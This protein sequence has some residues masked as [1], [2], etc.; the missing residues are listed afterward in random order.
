MN[1]P[2]L[3]LLKLDKSVNVR[4]ADESDI[5]FIAKAIIES[6]KSGTDIFAYSKI[7]EIDE[8]SFFE[9]LVN[10]ISEDIEGQEICVSGFLIAEIN[11]ERAACCCA[12]VEGTI[13]MNSAMIKSNLMSAFIPRE[14]LM[15]AAAKS[16]L[17][18]Q[19]FIERTKNAIQ[20]ESV[21]TVDK[22]R[23]IGLS[24]LLINEQIKRLKKDNIL[25]AELIVSGVNKNAI[26]VYQNIGFKISQSKCC[27][28]KNINQFLPSETV[29]LMRKSL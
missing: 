28:D 19:I 20:I 25:L 2:H 27:N 6:E 29:I 17:L 5:Q 7:Y 13:G 12:W 9:L 18:N 1:S 26:K 22:Y 24:S 16:T 3:K 14:N 11:N 21:Y 8:Q 10:M 15:K 4:P 23:G